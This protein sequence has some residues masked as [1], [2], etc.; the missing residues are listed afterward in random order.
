MGARVGE[1][2]AGGAPRGRRAGRTEVGV[3]V[4]TQGVGGG[5]RGRQGQFRVD[6]RP[7][8]LPRG[9]PTTR[10]RRHTSCQEPAALARSARTQPKR[11]FPVAAANQACAHRVRHPQIARGR[12]QRRWFR[13][14][15]A[16]CCLTPLSRAT[17]SLFVL[18]GAR[19][20][21]AK[22]AFDVM[23]GGDDGQPRQMDGFGQRPTTRDTKL[24][25]WTGVLNTFLSSLFPFAFHHRTDAES[26]LLSEASCRVRG[27][28]RAWLAQ[29]LDIGCTVG[30][31]WSWPRAAVVVAV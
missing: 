13:P 3:K 1:R 5:Q 21:E 15:D 9:L 29:E 28:I 14:P 7:G 22:Q 2:F 6:C 24:D 20:L 8:F 31:A 19:S 12:P 10:P 27:L 4:Q 17:S 11:R 23:V 18:G 25:G 30:L 26:A 16:R